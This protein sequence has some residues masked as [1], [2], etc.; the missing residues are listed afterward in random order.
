MDKFIEF[1]SNPTVLT[2]IIGLLV[3]GFAKTIVKI[4]TMG[5]TAK[6]DLVT[7]AEQQKFEETVRQDMRG[8]ATQVQ[9]TVMDT[10]LRVIERE[11]KGIS[12]FKDDVAE[13]QLMKV[14][15]ETEMKNALKDLDQ[16]SE[17]SSQVR[18][19]SSKVA[20]LEYGEK[21]SSDRRSE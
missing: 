7:K 1:L 15:L 16:M 2:T 8:Y 20:R 13:V 19:L 17:L 3:L 5:M 6:K 10:S 18:I 21:A 12:G 9:K 14:Q 11:L 4:Y